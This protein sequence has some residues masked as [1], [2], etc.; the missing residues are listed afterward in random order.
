MVMLSPPSTAATAPTSHTPSSLP[1]SILSEVGRQRLRAAEHHPS[2]GEM[3]ADV[4]QQ[5]AGQGDALRTLLEELAH[6]LAAGNMNVAQSRLTAV[7][8]PVRHNDERYHRLC[9]A[10]REAQHMLKAVQVT[11]LDG[12]RIL[13]ATHLRQLHATAS[14]I[15]AAFDEL[16]ICAQAWADLVET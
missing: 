6:D 3:N 12:S 10:Q 15:A 11:D 9:A 16:A 1:T 4:F 14:T 5:L 7:L 2:S 13:D 8:A